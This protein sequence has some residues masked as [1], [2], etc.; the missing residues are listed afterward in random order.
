M[1]SVVVSVLSNNKYHLNNKLEKSDLL[2]VQAFLFFETKSIKTK[3]HVQ[4]SFSSFAHLRHGE[5]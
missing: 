4:K 5:F 3:Y 1:I 2:K